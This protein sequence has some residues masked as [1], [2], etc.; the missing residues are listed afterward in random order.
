MGYKYNY[1]C[2]SMRETEGALTT[3]G[4]NVIT[5]DSKVLALKMEEGAK[6]QGMQL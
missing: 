1:K 2:P 5:E 6:I 4:G 3:E